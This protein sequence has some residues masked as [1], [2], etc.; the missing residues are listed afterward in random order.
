MVFGDQNLEISCLK[1][2]IYISNPG[3]YTI[4][5]QLKIGLDLVFGNVYDLHL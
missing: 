1:V 2:Y 5:F 3:N 4:S